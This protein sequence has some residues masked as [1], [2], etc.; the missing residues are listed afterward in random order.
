MGTPQ[1]PE[2]P[3]PMTHQSTLQHYF[4]NGRRSDE[5]SINGLRRMQNQFEMKNF[6]HSANLEMAMLHHATIY[7]KICFLSC[8]GTLRLQ[9][10]VPLSR[11]DGPR[12]RAKT[13]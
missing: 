3:T 2:G 11:I 5:N 7:A 12:Q 13:G 1:A 6:C 9:L 8:G 10:V 4:N